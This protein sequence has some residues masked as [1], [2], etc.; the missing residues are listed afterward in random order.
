MVDCLGGATGNALSSLYFQS[1]ALTVVIPPWG[2]VGP[3][4]S[5]VI[6]WVGL[7]L[8]AVEPHALEFG[9]RY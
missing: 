8:C 1:L 4:L 6:T 5:P 2:S 9:C 7:G 3:D